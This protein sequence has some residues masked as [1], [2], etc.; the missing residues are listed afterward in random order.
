MESPFKAMVALKQPGRIEARSVIERMK[1]RF[2]AFASHPEPRVIDVPEDVRGRHDVQY[3]GFGNLVIELLFLDRP[4]LNAMVEDAVER[5]IFW[6]EAADIMAGHG[7]HAMLSA[8]LPKIESG[9]DAVLLA[10]ATT[11][12]SAAL[13][14]LMPAVGVLW[15]ESGSVIEIGHFQAGAEQM[16]AGDIPVNLWVGFQPIRGQEA[17]YGRKTGTTNTPPIGILTTG[18]YPFIQREVDFLP[19]DRKLGDI[20]LYTDIACRNILVRGGE[21]PDGDVIKVNSRNRSGCGPCRKDSGPDCRSG[22]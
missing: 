15:R 17:W 4:I 12:A 22:P 9:K 3:M 13:A 18:M 5:S 6:P 8:A 14:D 21:V 19:V 20:A 10:A 1:D 11:F 16:K 2:P 7:G